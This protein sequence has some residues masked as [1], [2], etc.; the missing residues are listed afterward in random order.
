MATPV[1]VL[2]S[3]LGA[4][5]AALLFLSLYRVSPSTTC[6]Q[7]QT[8]T[9]MRPEA[10]RTRWTP[11]I[12]MIDGFTVAES[13]QIVADCNAHLNLSWAQI[14]L[15]STTREGQ[16]SEVRKTLVAPVPKEGRFVWIYERI[17]AQVREKNSESWRFNLPTNPFDAAVETMSFLQYDASFDGHYNWHVD[18]SEVR[19]HRRLSVTVQ[20]TDPSEYEGG[21]FEVQVGSEPSVLPK[22]QGKITAFPSFVLH[23]VTPVTKG[24]RNALVFWL[25]EAGEPIP[26]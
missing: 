16:V 11:V 26:E 8:Q 9:S 25:A 19:F 17:L 2:D 21:S 4:L 7:T 3:C 15:P 20:L 22:S 14:G 5:L 13:H 23:R 12:T 1:T 6:N 18:F 24:S 10:A